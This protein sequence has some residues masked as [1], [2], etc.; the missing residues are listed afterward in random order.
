[1]NFFRVIRQISLKYFLYEESRIENYSAG[2]EQ[3]DNLAMAL[4]KKTSAHLREK[5]ENFISHNNATKIE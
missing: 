1:M 4:W 2:H 3:S 5:T